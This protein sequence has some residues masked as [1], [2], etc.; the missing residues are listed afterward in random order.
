[1]TVWAIANK[2]ALYILAPVFC[3]RMLPFLLGKYLE[4]HCS[5]NITLVLKPEA[6]ENLYDLCRALPPWLGGGTVTSDALSSQSSFEDVF[7]PSQERGQGVSRTLYSKLTGPEDL[8]M[9]FTWL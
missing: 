3:G 2:A 6:L 1:M 8:E 7:C 9:P 5:A 4:W